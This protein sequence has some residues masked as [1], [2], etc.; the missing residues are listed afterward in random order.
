MKTRAASALLWET[1]MLT[2]WG[3]LSRLFVALAFLA[4]FMTLYETR[5]TVREDDLSGLR[6]ISF[7]IAFLCALSGL[8]LGRLEARHGFPFYLGFS[9]P[10]PTWLQVVVPM[11][12]RTLF[13]T[14]LFYVPLLVTDLLYDMPA[15]FLWASLLM[16]PI[17][18]MAIASQWWTDKKG[19]AHLIGWLSVCAIS[20]VLVYKT[21]HIGEINIEDDPEFDWMWMFSFSL[22]D[23][24]MI[25]VVSAVSIATSLFGVE[26]QRHG[27]D[28]LGTWFAVDPNSSQQFGADWFAELYQ[29]D[30]P[31]TSAKRAEFWSEINGRA[32]PVFVWSMMGALTLPS[33]WLLANFSDYVVVWATITFFIA[34]IP[35]SGRPTLGIVTKQGATYLSTFDATRPINTAWLAGM[36]LG[37]SIVS[38]VAGMLVIAISMW[39]SAPLLEGF[40]F[41]VETFKE[42]V[43][44]YV[45]TEPHLHIVLSLVV[46]LVQFST[47]VVFLAVL[48]TTYALYSD[49]LSFGMLWL[50]LYACV[51]PITI[52]MKLVPVSV[53]V[54]HVWLATG[55]IAV[56]AVYFIYSLA[57]ERVMSAGQLLEFVLIW[58]LYALAYF[59]LQR[60]DGL[61]EPEVP[62]EFIVFRVGICLLSLTLF[63]LA[64]WS[65]ARARHR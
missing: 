6:L 37:V 15:F 14:A 39:F 51:L 34:C 53:G 32:L 48:H 54:N 25:T 38:M 33:L 5:D 57:K 43:F 18:L 9:R 23:Y 13:C 47:M 65:L 20:C 50:M 19:I 21:L 12:Y 16:I 64:P 62:T 2:R 63:A 3:F 24:A 58:I 36:K 42:F 29:T 56:G 44:D 1:W 61:F 4:M 60:E 26:N 46:Y 52:A 22:K 40:I 59:Y 41:S 45:E 31:T 28:Q 49:R 35:L 27:D 10:I 17:T 11:V 7:D 30:C 55:L 8:G